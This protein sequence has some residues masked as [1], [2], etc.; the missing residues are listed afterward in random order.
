MQGNSVP[1]PTDFGVGL[2]T[3]LFTQSK[4]GIEVPTV[5]KLDVNTP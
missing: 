2:N 3:G 5:V 1:A 4:H